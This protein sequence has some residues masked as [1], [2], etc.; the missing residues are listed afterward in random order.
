MCVQAEFLVIRESLFAVA[1]LVAPGTT[2]ILGDTTVQS[3]RRVGGS[4]L[5]RLHQLR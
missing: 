1:L 4:M 5:F 2:T 3:K